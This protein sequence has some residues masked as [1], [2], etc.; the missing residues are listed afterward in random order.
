MPNDSE[1]FDALW[2]R[3]DRGAIDAKDSQ[4]ATIR[5]AEAYR[6]LSDDARREADDCVRRWIVRGTDR[7]R[8]DAVALIRDFE[9]VSAREA[10]A[11]RLAFLRRHAGTAPGVAETEKLRELLDQMPAE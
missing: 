10:V 1:S 6:G 3:L 9:I 4:Q 8:F 7:Q 5:L 2:H 11:E